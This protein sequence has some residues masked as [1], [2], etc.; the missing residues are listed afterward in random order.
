MNNRIKQCFKIQFSSQEERNDFLNL[1]EIKEIDVH[2]YLDTFKENST[3]PI[4]AEGVVF[5]D[6]EDL[7]DLS[8]IFPTL[9]NR[10]SEKFIF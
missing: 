6:L 3:K 4:D 5:I 2:Y 8:K 1:L 10:T 9:Q 7:D